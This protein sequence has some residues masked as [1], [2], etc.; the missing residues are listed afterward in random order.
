M[1]NLF[2][3]LKSLFLKL[4]TQ[5]PQIVISPPNNLTGKVIFITGASTG[6]GLATALRLQALGAS[7]MIASLDSEHLHAIPK[8]ERLEIIS[9][10]ITQ[11]K[12]VQ[13]ALETTHKI[14]GRIDVVI[15]NA[16]IFLEKSLENVTEKEFDAMINVNIK[17]MFFCCKYALP[18]MKKQKS[19]LV[20]NIGSKISHNS[21]VT[22]N[23]VFYATTKYAVEGFSLALR[24]EVFGSGVRVTCLMPGTVSTFPSP[25]SSTY[26]EKEELASVIAH[27]IQHEHISFETVIIQSVGQQL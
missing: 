12:D 24:N 1:K 3:A 16:G 5:A 27:M 19:G 26:L 14:F 8:L 7:V 18:E 23:K 22:K 13:N 2:P 15:N 20:I 21:A 4:T 25:L 10:D 6:I 9:C 11:E 17:G